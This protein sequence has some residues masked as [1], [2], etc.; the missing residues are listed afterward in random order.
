MFDSVLVKWRPRTPSHV[1]VM[2]L[3]I[4]MLMK[5][6]DNDDDDNTNNDNTNTIDTTNNN[7]HNNQNHNSDNA[8]NNNRRG[9]RL[10]RHCTPA[11]S[12]P[13]RARARVPVLLVSS[14]CAASW[15][16]GLLTGCVPLGVSFAVGQAGYVQVYF[17]YG[18]TTTSTTY[19]SYIHKTDCS[20]AW[21]AFHLKLV[22]SLFV[23]SEIMK[24][25]LL[26]WLL[27][28]PM[29]TYGCVSQRWDLTMMNNLEH[30]YL[31]ARWCCYLSVSIKLARTTNTNNHVCKCRAFRYELHVWLAGT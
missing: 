31:Q 4:I 11:P 3:L 26:K 23:S 10:G 18:F 20:A 25:R 5:H 16:A 7:D 2:T 6:D 9:A 17:M 27:D 24:C 22:A 1:A 13:A 8:T 15:L 21:S 28:H 12:P 19:V 29:N 14:R 30:R